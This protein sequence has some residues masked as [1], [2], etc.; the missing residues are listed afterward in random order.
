M[1]PMVTGPQV[2][3]WRGQFGDEYTARNQIDP[4]R[5]RRRMR[6]WAGIL[7]RLGG[8]PPQSILE[9]GANIGGNLA[10]LKAVSDAELWALE[11]NNLARTQLVANGIVPADR[12]LS[13]EAKAIP[14]PSGRVDLA[15]TVGVLIHI[16][17]DDLLQICSEIHR[18]ASKYVFCSEYFAD[19]PEDKAYRSHQGLLFKRDFGAF[20]LDNFSDLELIDCGFSWKRTTG[21]DN[22]TWWLFRKV[23]RDTSR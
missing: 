20:Y 15:F 10:A 3:H 23:S 17:P 2:D 9:V 4:E 6:F 7:E 13:A 8:A 22:L 5:L 21:F 14:L 12:A 19:Q 11:P 1:D 16:A 18:C